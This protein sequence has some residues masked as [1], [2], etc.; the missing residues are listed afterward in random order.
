MDLRRDRL[1]QPRENQSVRTCRREDSLRNDGYGGTTGRVSAK[2]FTLLEVMIAMAIL[3]IALVAVFQSHSQSLSMA[4]N[5]RF[6]TTASLLAQKRMAEFEA[7]SG[8]QVQ[9]EQGDFGEDFAAYTWTVVV[10]NTEIGM[11]KK[12]EVTVTNSGMKRN[13]TYMLVY[14]RFTPPPLPSGTL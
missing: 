9:S 7:T 14:Y 2:G 11:I 8:I 1:F 10:S 13:N 5:A 3:A 4:D 6:L 12:I